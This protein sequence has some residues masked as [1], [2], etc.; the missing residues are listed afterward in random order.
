MTDD[1]SAILHLPTSLAM[2]LQGAGVELLAASLEADMG[3]QLWDA[4]GLAFFL[5]SSTENHFGFEKIA[6]GLHWQS[7]AQLCLDERGEPVSPDQFPISAVLATGKSSAEIAVQIVGV[8]N[9]RR[10]IRISAQPLKHPES[11][12]FMV[13][14]TTIDVTESYDERERLQYQAYHKIYLQYIL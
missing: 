13:F 5:N 2:A 7:L 3:I 14:S 1:C 6:P 8:T 9:G 11:G 4:E 10:W 12:V